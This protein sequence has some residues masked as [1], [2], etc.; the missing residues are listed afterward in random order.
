VTPA[1]RV[2]F[3]ASV[4]GAAQRLELEWPMIVYPG[5][6]DWPLKQDAPDEVWLTLIGR[7]GWVA[8]LRDKRVRYRPAEWHALETH[9]VRAVNIT[10]NRN[11]GLEEQTD[12]LGRH[13]PAIVQLTAEAP[14]Y[15]HLTLGGLELKVR[16]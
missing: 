5:H 9:R 7:L 6:P 4:I 11:L 2:F 16:H 10:T 15:Y 3:D 8:V 1:G 14:G 13:M 12:L